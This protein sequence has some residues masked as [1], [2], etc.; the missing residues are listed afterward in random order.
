MKGDAASRG[1]FIVQG[2]ILLENLI[3]DTPHQNLRL[4]IRMLLLSYA[5]VAWALLTRSQSKRL[6]PSTPVNVISRILGP[7][8]SF[9]VTNRRNKDKNFDTAVWTQCDRVRASV[10]APCVVIEI[11]SDL[12]P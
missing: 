12:D 6:T 7:G 5:H 8:D 9:G 10:A 4:S 11:R 2:S 1:I 3:S